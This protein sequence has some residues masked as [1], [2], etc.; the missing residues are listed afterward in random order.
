[1]KASK[2][3]VCD[4]PFTAPFRLY[5]PRL[6]RRVRPAQNTCRHTPGAPDNTRVTVQARAMEIRRLAI[7]HASDAAHVTWAAPRTQSQTRAAPSLWTVNSQPSRS[8]H[9]RRRMYGRARRAR[10]A[11]ACSSCETTR[12]T[13]ARSA[14]SG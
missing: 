1:V 2:Q 3:A 14:R 10:K 4:L 13:R 11:S 8:R 12:N 6:F 5:I 9:S 7:G